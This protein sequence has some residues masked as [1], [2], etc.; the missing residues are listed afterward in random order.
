MNDLDFFFLHL[1]EVTFSKVLKEIK[2]KKRK[3]I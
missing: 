2:K 3:R 1:F